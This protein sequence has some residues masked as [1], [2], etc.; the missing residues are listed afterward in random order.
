MMFAS[1]HGPIGILP[2]PINVKATVRGTTVAVGDVVVTSAIHSSATF[3]P[4]ANG[5]AL[6]IFNNVRIIDGNEARNNGY[7]GVVTS[8]LGTDGSAGNAVAIQFGGIV[9]AKVTASAALDPGALLG[10]AD[11]GAALTDTG[12][13]MTSTVPCAI[14]CETVSGSGTAQR[15]VFVPLQYWFPA[16][17]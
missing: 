6:Y 1:N 15:R 9:T 5:D 17:I 16:A 14:L 7:V 11:A 8:L 10:A 13:T 4:N 2:A 12:G 3:D